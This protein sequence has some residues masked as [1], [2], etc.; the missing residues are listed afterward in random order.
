[1]I[2]IP[3]V[4]SPESSEAPDTHWATSVSLGL[5]RGPLGA[6][7]SVDT[8][9][10]FPAP[11]PSQVIPTATLKEDAVTSLILQIRK[12]RHK[13]SQRGVELPKATNL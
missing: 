13:E 10:L 11:V 9:E 5:A 2:V 4:P 7:S 8:C 6:E 12:L 3:S 1:M